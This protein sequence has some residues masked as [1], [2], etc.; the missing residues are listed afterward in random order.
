MRPGAS[1]ARRRHDPLRLRGRLAHREKARQG[2]AC[3]CGKGVCGVGASARV[4][5]DRRGRVEQD[6][7]LRGAPLLPLVPLSS[8]RGQTG[9]H[10]PAQNLSLYPRPQLLVTCSPEACKHP[11][12]PPS[13]L[14]LSL[15]VA[16]NPKCSRRSLLGAIFLLFLDVS[17]LGQCGCR[18]RLRD[19]R[20]RRRL[21]HPSV[22]HYGVLQGGLGGRCRTLVSLCMAREGEGW[23]R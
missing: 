4:L 20:R 17:R 8:L 19:C 1:G 18:R 5:A 13:S 10:P 9:T 22:L 16:L 15:T 21:P 2:S 12:R 23:L 11:S 6:R 7:T 14:P 3:A